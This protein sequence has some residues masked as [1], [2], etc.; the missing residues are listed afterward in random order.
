MSGD[1]SDKNQIN[2]LIARILIAKPDLT[3]DIL[4]II[5]P[6]ID[7]Y[8]DNALN[9][10]IQTQKRQIKKRRPVYR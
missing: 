6:N 3:P 5:V 2:T 10:K 9:Q 7:H 1:R 8:D 4:R